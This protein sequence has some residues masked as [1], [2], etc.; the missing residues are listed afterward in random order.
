MKEDALSKFVAEM[1]EILKSAKDFTLA[2]VPDV[3]QQVLRWQLAHAI[4]HMVLGLIFIIVAYNVKSAASRVLAKAV[5][6]DKEGGYRN[7]DWTD[8]SEIVVP[9]LF[10]IV[11]AA[12]TGT[13]MLLSNLED[14]IQITIAPKVYLIEYFATL[15][16][17][18]S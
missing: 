5:T 6:K 16:K 3:I 11:I 18:H 17:T 8:H 14:V 7:T 13:I 15:V 9:G 2:Q 12:V 1:T 10:G 4:Y